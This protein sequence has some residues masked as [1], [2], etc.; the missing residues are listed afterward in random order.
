M[1]R[2]LKLHEEF[3]EILGNNNVYFQ[4][5]AS[6][7]MSYPCVKYSRDPGADRHNANNKLYMST[8][9]YETIV[10]DRNPSTDIPD[11]IL[12]HFSM[13]TLDRTYSA[14]NLNH[15]VFTIYY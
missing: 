3:K 6:I 2:R 9:R 11:K 15:Y 4:P 13:C 8:D 12:H 14:D 5:P 1:V 7:K 10:I